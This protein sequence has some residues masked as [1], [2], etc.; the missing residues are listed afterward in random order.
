[1]TESLVELQGDFLHEGTRALR[2][3]TRAML[4]ERLG[5][6]ESTVSRAT[7]DKYVLLP[8]RRAVSYDVFFKAS[9]SVREAIRELVASEQTAL[10]DRAISDRLRLA[11]YRVA[12]R[13]IAKYRAQLGILPS[14]YR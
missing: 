14:T 12:R 11:G 5:V 7:A 9:L 1:M 2:P 13:T 4:A 6:H 3:V 8:D 10:T